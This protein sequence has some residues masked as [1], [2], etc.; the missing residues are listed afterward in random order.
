V[1]EHLPVASR[2]QLA[3]AVKVL[4]VAAEKLLP[5]LLVLQVTLPVGAIVV[6]GLVSVTVA[7]HVIGALMAVEGD[8][9]ATLVAVVRLLTS[10]VAVP[11]LPWYRAPL[12][13]R[14]G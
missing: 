12:A 5:V 13:V 11:V 6:P 8:A 2:V 9:H 1:T 10:R 14:S 3:G 7:V 4:P